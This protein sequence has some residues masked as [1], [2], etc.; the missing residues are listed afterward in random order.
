[1]AVAKEKVATE[2]GAA[3][4]VGGEAR[5]DVDTSPR[6][7]GGGEAERKE[8]VVRVAVGWAAARAVAAEA[9]GAE[10]GGA[11]EEGRARGAA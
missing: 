7:T 8:G 1:V 6:C 5:V 3:T 4:K 2:G 10:E 9:V 11:G